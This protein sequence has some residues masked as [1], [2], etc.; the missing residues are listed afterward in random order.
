MEPYMKDGDVFEVIKDW[1]IDNNPWRRS[2]YTVDYYTLLP[3]LHIP[4][5]IV[6]GAIGEETQLGYWRYLEYF[7]K[8]VTA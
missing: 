5:T 7:R 2:R 3:N 8:V 6:V 4:N 1:D